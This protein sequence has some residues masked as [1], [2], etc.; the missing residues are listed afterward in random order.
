MF[1]QPGNYLRGTMPKPLLLFPN[2]LDPNIEHIFIPLCE[3]LLDNQIQ[4]L[5]EQVADHLEHVYA[6]LGRNEFIDVSVAEQIAERLTIL[7]NE[8]TTIPETK[9]R[10][11]VGAA[12]Y[13]VQDRDAQADLSSILGFDDDLIVLNYVLTE[14]GRQNLK[15]DA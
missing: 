3:D 7:L 13:F 8:I 15:V 11:V 10:L 14:L 2:L 9:R 12:R 4:K 6:A 5:C 1:L